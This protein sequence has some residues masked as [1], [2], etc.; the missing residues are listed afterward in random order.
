M[1]KLTIIF[2]SLLTIAAPVFAQV[3]GESNSDFF[4]QGTQQ[5]EQEVQQLQRPE[6][7][8]LE[9]KEQQA[10]QGLNIQQS[11][12]EVQEVPEQTPAIDPNVPEGAE[13]E[14]ETKF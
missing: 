5:I 6:P 3:R 2:L 1:F 11:Q 10:E 13:Q 12:P 7:P 4:E 9:Q 8:T 14:V